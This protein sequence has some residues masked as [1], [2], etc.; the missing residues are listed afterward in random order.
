L[1]ESPKTKVLGESDSEDE[2]LVR[3]NKT[4]NTPKPIEVKTSESAATNNPYRRS[5]KGSPSLEHLVRTKKISIHQPAA[6]ASKVK[7]SMHG[8]FVG[9][10]MSSKTSPQNVGH[11]KRGKVK[12]AHI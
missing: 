10:T 8:S 1:Q 7:E 11:R 4:S 12:I 6:E 2:A 5:L 3:K 9:R